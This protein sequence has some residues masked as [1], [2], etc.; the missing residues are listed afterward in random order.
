MRA[1]V[2]A[3]CCGEVEEKGGVRNTNSICCQLHKKI[4][5]F[6]S[7]E[8]Y[9]FRF[10]CPLLLRDYG[11]RAKKKKVQ[12]VLYLFRGRGSVHLTPPCLPSRGILIV[13]RAMCPQKLQL[14][15]L[16]VLPLDCARPTRGR[17]SLNIPER[18]EDTRFSKCSYRLAVIITATHFCSGWLP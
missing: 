18:K 11:S 14:S 17:L 4:S 16:I 15:Y 6:T 13:P 3:K 8:K 7:G 10:K 5:N 1:V 12:R 9:S 2:A